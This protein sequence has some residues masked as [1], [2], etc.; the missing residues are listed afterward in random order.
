[1]SAAA[2]AGA[3]VSVQSFRVLPWTTEWLAS[4]W[5]LAAWFAPFWFVGNWLTGQREAIV[6]LLA[7]SLVAWPIGVCLICILLT[8]LEDSCIACD[9]G[10]PSAADSDAPTPPARVPDPPV[11]RDA[12]AELQAV[13]ASI[14]HNA[15]QLFHARIEAETGLA[16]SVATALHRAS[17]EFPRHAAELRALDVV[18]ACLDMVV[19]ADHERRRLFTAARGTDNKLRRATLPRDIGN[20][21]LVVFGLGPRRVRRLTRAY[22]QACEHCPGYASFGAGH[23]LGGTVIH[24]LAV[25]AEVG[26]RSSAFRRVD[27]FNPGSSPL[28]K[29]FPRRRP[30]RTEVH[31]HRVVGDLV[32]RFHSKE[33]VRHEHRRVQGVHPHLL[34]H[35]LPAAG[36]AEV[37]AGEVTQGSREEDEASTEIEEVVA[38]Q[39]RDHLRFQEIGSLARS[40]PSLPGA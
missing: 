26:S 5:M 21:A 20:D 16:E 39:S 32:S 2:G 11:S 10:V 33:G 19:L 24:G 3:V 30:K 31:C 37:A 29:V 22:A 34:T 18:H 27:L 7:W 38:P 25:W 9:V 23:S 40:L 8:K 17:L 35:F 4:L 14:P 36:E 12:F 28:A 13:I 1:M 6:L 15:L